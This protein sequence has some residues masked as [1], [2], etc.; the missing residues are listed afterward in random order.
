[1][2]KF[3]WKT[4]LPFHRKQTHVLLLLSWPWPDDLGIRSWVEVS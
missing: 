3:N 1:M 4:R 2:T